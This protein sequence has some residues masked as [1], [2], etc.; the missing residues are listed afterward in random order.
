MKSSFFAILYLFSSFNAWGKEIISETFDPGSGKLLALNDPNIQAV[1]MDT[2]YRWSGYHGGLWGFGLLND[3]QYDAGI[4]LDISGVNSGHYG[5]INAWTIF[6]GD[7]VSDLRAITFKWGKTSATGNIQA[8]AL[9][10]DANKEWFVSDAYVQDEKGKAF[11]ID[12]VATVWRKLNEA[13]V[14]NKL[15]QLENLPENNPDLSKVYGGG[16]VTVGIGNGNQTRLENLIWSTAIRDFGYYIP[17]RR[18]VCLRG[19]LAAGEPRPTVALDYWM[20]DGSETN[21]VEIPYSS[22]KDSGHF[23][24]T[25]DQ[26][27]PGA[28][29]YRFKAVN[30]I[31]TARTEPN[32]FSVDEGVTLADQIIEEFGYPKNFPVQDPPYGL[33]A[34]E[35]VSST[36]GYAWSGIGGGHAIVWNGT[37]R[38]SKGIS[39][40]SYDRPISGDLWA[41]FGGMAVDRPVSFQVS[42]MPE[43]THETALFYPMIQDTDGEWFIAKTAIDLNSG[44]RELLLAD[45][46]WSRIDPPV[47]GKAYRRIGPGNPDLTRITGGGIGFDGTGTKDI[48]IASLKWSGSEAPTI[49]NLGQVPANTPFTEVVL[50]GNLDAG[51]PLPDV[52]ALVWAKGST[53]TSRYACAT[54]PGLFRV[55]IPMAELGTYEFCFE[56]KEKEGTKRSISATDTFTLKIPEASALTPIVETFGYPTDHDASETKC[57]SDLAPIRSGTTGYAWSG[58]GGGYE[59]FWMRAEDDPSDGHLILSSFELDVAGNFWTTFEREQVA[60]SVTNRLV[61]KI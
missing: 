34:N 35:G 3:T 14:I 48:L 39:L 9:I 19:K 13:P 15:I 51:V 28:Y 50:Q 1:S 53:V 41:V 46:A 59:M 5:D 12:A 10:Q 45:Q 57:N 18:S 55:N 58:R 31:T 8:K 20:Q 49:T 32:S 33:A 43:S 16:F 38:G 30:E 17:D 27:Q 7:F 22:I 47:R 25:L 56:A 40:N 54:G 37:K 44:A 23:S 24:V 4:C 6:N 11:T 26:L 36:T 21:T 29:G 42:M 61:E 52:S 60:A 2:G